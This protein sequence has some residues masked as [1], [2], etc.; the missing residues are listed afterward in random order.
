[1]FYNYIILRGVKNYD[2]SSKIHFGDNN[3]NEI[4][5]DL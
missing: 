5:T 4:K 2:N 3:E 1:M